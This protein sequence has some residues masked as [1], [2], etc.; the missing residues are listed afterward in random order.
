[1]VSTRKST[2]MF[3]QTREITINV[4]FFDAGV[5]RAKEVRPCL[6]ALRLS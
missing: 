4:G 5:T 2:V 6:L 3:D 1:M